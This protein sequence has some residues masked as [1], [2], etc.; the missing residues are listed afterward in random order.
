MSNGLFIKLT[1][2]KGFYLLV[3]A[4]HIVSIKGGEC[5][6]GE[7]FSEIIT[8]HQ[9]FA[10]RVKETVEAINRKIRRARSC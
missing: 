6:D 3:N 10:F 7:I 8:D 4:S 2:R 5:E 9:G 1:T